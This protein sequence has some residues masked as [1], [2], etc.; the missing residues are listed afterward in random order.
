MSYEIYF[1]KRKDLTSKN[2]EKILESEALKTDNHFINK[3]KML[4]LKDKFIQQGLKFSVFEKPNEDYIELNFPTYQVSMFNNQFAISATYWESNS[5]DV[6]NNEIKL[7]TNILLDNGFT[8][9]DPQT[10]EFILSKYEIN[11]TYTESKS[12]IDKTR[13]IQTGKNFTYTYIGI[14]TAIFLFGLII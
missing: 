8:G 7:I 11:K 12:V 9:Y 13:Y 5:N 14:G 4:E 3:H 1:I 6:I 2:I 10:E